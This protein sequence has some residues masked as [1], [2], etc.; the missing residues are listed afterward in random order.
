MNAKQVFITMILAGIAQLGA[1][2]L[3][4]PD[5]TQ[6][7]DP[8]DPGAITNGMVSLFPSPYLAANEVGGGGHFSR[9]ALQLVYSFIVTGGPDGVFV[10]V[11]IS[12]SM[13]ATAST[14]P[15]DDGGGNA[16]VLVDTYLDRASAVHTSNDGTGATGWGGFLGVNALS[17]I[18]GYSINTITIQVSAGSDNGWAKADAST[19][20]FIDPSF[21]NSAGYTIQLS[22]GVGNSASSAAPEPATFG[23]I[24]LTL[25]GAGFVRR[26]RGERRATSGR[27]RA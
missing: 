20:I 16:A 22:D 14:N 11:D 18:D 2:T 26:R 12:Y 10:P 7:Y 27:A 4:P 21:D 24:G 6:T 25:C 13:G 5:L 1:S 15:G 9:S 17:G 23:L 3:P 8:Q 19:L